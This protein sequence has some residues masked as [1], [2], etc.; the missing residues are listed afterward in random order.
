MLSLRLG[1]IIFVFSIYSGPLGT[2]ALSCSP[3]AIHADGE[4][5]SPYIL[6]VGHIS[7]SG[8]SFGKLLAPFGQFALNARNRSNG[9]ECNDVS[10]QR[11]GSTTSVASSW[12]FCYGSET[13]EVVLTYKPG[14]LCSTK[15]CLSVCSHAVLIFCEYQKQI[16]QG[17]KNRLWWLLACSG[18]RRKFRHYAI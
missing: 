8:V 15:T 13:K 1:L 4:H 14:R 9:V 6:P 11:H 10:W 7:M 2:L 12:L 5:R 3:P 17:H 18:S 16:F